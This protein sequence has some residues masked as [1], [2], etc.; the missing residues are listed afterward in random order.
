MRALLVDD[1]AL[2]RSNLRQA[3]IEV[4]GW[5]V[6]GDCESAE[7]ARRLL[8]TTPADVVFLDIQMP[9]ESGLMLARSLLDAESPPVIVFVTAYDQ[10]AVEA[11]DVHALDYLLK[12]FDD[13]RLAQTLERASALVELRQQSVWRDA[14]GDAVSSIE[15]D[16]QQG[17]PAPL[18]R[19]CVRSVGRIESVHLDSVHWIA[20]AGN[21]VELHLEARAVLH[22]AALSQMERHLDTGTFL[23]VHRT[24]IV[25]RSSINSLHVTGDGTYRLVTTNGDSVPVSERYVA[26]VREIIEQE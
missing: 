4:P 20:S 17:K 7:S 24:A 8:A 19:V 21:Y 18:T 3:I 26:K 2:A 16:R 23:R 10:Y 6:V 9:Q 22:R 1:E 15:A 5:Q 12:P 11:F 13:S 25:R 14:V